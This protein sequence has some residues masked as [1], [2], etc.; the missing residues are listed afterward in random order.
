MT[1]VGTIDVIASI[2]TA[3]YDQGA[4]KIEKT[5]KDLE[6][7]VNNSGRSFKSFASEAGTAFDSVASSIGNLLKVSVALGVGGAFGLS[8]FVKQAS[9]LQSIRASFESMTGSAE[10]ANKVLQQLNDFSFKTAFSTADINAAARTFLGAGAAV[11]D[12]G[13]IMSQVGDIA[14]ATG[15]DLGRL[16][17]PLS[18]ALARGKLQTQDFYQILDSGA[19]SLGKALREEL[20]VRGM[21]D[22]MKAMEEGKVTADILFDVIE[23]QTKEGGFAFQGAIKQADTFAGRMSNLQETI[24]N[25]ALEILGVDKATGM[26]DPDGIFQKMSDSVQSATKWLTDNKTQITEIAKTVVDNFVPAVLG[27]ATAYGVARAAA[28]AFT[29][30]SSTNII[31]LIANAVALLVAGLVFLELKF[32]IFTNTFAK[33]QEVMQ[34]FIDWLVTYVYPVLQQIGAFI[35]ERF[36]A[37]W[38]NLKSAFDSLNEALAPLGISFK[39]IAMIIGVVLLA[40]LLILIANIVV[41]VTIF[42]VLVEAISWVIRTVSEFVGAV[43]RASTAIA[44]HLA[45]LAQTIGRF[46]TDMWTSVVSIWNGAVGYFRGIFNGIVDVINRA[47]SALNASLGS[48]GK[49]FGFSVQIPGI[50]KLADGGI[51]SSATLAV[52]GEGREPEAVIPLS[53][54]DAMMNNEGGGGSEYNIGNI[55][56]S[57]EVDGERWLRRLTDNQEDVSNGLVPLQRYM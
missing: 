50:P 32:K 51:V 9:D 48:I 20:A 57:T 39:D 44:N 26:V 19:G 16:T 42:S 31:G 33:I 54:L 29:L 38:D 5:N 35:A 45:P 2:D 47:I 11:D 17:L 12:L 27:I 23:K 41:L 25:V 56:I 28:I 15:A 14:G 52:I 6:R 22:F 36:M 18:Q 55:N 10:G 40:P 7:S 53:K 49:T 46:F 8:Q 13:T 1:T 43:I 30:A 4:S 24:G 21:G 34:P 3:K 37:A